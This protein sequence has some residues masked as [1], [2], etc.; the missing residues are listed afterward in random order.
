MG[1]KRYMLCRSA[2]ALTVGALS[3]V[4]LFAPC[5][6][7][8][9]AHAHHAMPAGAAGS[10]YKLSS[11]RYTVPDI[12]LVSSDGKLV[13]L[14]ALLQQHRPVLLQFVYTTCTTVCPVLSATFSQAQGRLAARQADYAMVSI[15]IDP[16]HDTPQKLAAYAQRFDAGPRWTFLTGK[17]DAIHAA[18]RAFDATYPSNNKMNHQPITFLKPA[19]AEVWKRI[20]GFAAVDELMQVY[21]TL[22]TSPTTV[23]H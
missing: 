6:Q 2:L 11:A 23:A 10:G 5:A 3:G 22:G 9:D 17:A 1:S 12:T 19:D 21:A 20:D 13:S 4:A 18:L 14:R 7:A 16:E 8:H 15:S